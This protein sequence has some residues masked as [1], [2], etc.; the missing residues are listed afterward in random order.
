[1]DNIT[2]VGLEVHKAKVCVAVAESGRGGEVRQADRGFREPPR[3][4][5]QDGGKTQQGRPSPELLL[6]SRSVRVRAS[7]FADRLRAQ[8]HRSGDLADP[9]EVG[10]PGQ[11]GSSRRDD[12]DKGR[13]SDLV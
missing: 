6:R 1:M 3:D 11:D 7:P 13:V 2:Y 12:A 5:V 10:R 9:D 4:P 8:L